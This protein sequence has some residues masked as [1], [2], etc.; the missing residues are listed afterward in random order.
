[1]EA[2]EKYFI[3]YAAKFNKWSQDLGGFIEKIEPRAFEKTIQEA[4]IRCLFNH[5]PNYVL[6]RNKAKTLDVWEDET[7]LAF[8]ALIPETTFG[9]DLRI[10]ILRGDISQC[11][12]GFEKVRDQWDVL[13]GERTLK[14]LKLFDVSPVTFPAYLDTNVQARD[15]INLRSRALRKME[16]YK[17]FDFEKLIQAAKSTE[18]HFLDKNAA[19]AL[20]IKIELGV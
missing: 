18:D 15:L 17:R 16:I 20:R 3:G 6:G 10:S 11:S 13:A 2:D 1:M 9:K 7:G 19:L 12:F 4:D 14:E 5:D 8:K